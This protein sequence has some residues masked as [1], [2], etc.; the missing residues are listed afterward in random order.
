V[1]DGIN[2]SSK[3]LTEE[4]V[5]NCRSKGIKLGVWIDMLAI[6]AEKEGT[7]FY[8]KILDMGVDFFCSDFPLN[9]ISARENWT[10]CKENNMRKDHSFHKQASSIL[11]CNSFTAPPAYS[12]ETEN[13][14]VQ[15]PVLK[16]EHFKQ[17]CYN[18]FFSDKNFDSEISTISNTTK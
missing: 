5:N 6:P 17:I 4:V 16:E 3:K 9:I 15:D 7:E 2:I 10:N 11:T 1:A 14:L 13:T 8:S 18:D 12:C